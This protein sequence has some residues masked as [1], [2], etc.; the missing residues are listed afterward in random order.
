MDRTYSTWDEVPDDARLRPRE[1]YRLSPQITPKDLRKWRTQGELECMRLSE[2]LPGVFG[3]GDHPYYY[4]HGIKRKLGIPLKP[5][6]QITPLA[7]PAAPRP[8]PALLRLRQVISISGFCRDFVERLVQEHQLQPFHKKKGAKALYPAW[9]V[10]KFF[11]EKLGCP[12]YPTIRSEPCSKFL[13]RRE[14][15]TWLGVPSA[16]LESWVTFRWIHRHKGRYDREEIKRTILRQPLAKNASKT[17]K[18]GSFGK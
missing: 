6:P 8:C 10:R 18:T 1:I 14:V 2:R 13:R 5:R 7:P 3:P 9:Q 11:K 17:R 16:E 12:D 4:A 15:I